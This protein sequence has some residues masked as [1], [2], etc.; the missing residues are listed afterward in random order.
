MMLEELAANMFFLAA[1]S[2][3]GREDEQ[4]LIHAL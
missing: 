1:G 4:R 2:A 3:P